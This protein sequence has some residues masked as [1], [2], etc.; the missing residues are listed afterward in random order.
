MTAL[1]VH[2][3][4]QRKHVTSLAER[5]HAVGKI[6]VAIRFG[7]WAAGRRTTPTWQ[8]IQSHL[9]CSEA[10]AFRYRAYLRAARGEA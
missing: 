5:M 10:T 6:D 4:P 3:P 9:Q 7:L 1:S 2:Q 8:E